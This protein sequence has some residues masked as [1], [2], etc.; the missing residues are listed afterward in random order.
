MASI[1]TNYIIGGSMNSSLINVLNE[2]KDLNIED[3]DE[4]YIITSSYNQNGNKN[5]TD[6]II[7]DF[8]NYENVLKENNII[9]NEQTLLI[10]EMDY[11]L[12]DF[13]VPII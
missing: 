10:F 5:T 6:K 12:D 1:I 3:Q 7:I 8:R 9:Y 13:L 4:N 2:N 11:Y